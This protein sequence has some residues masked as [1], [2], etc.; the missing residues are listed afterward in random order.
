[1]PC[2]SDYMNPTEKESNSVEVLGFLKE[3]GEK[4][5]KYDSYYG[6]IETLD[7]DVAK[8]CSFCQKNDV[9]KYSLELQIWWRDHKKADKE[10]VKKEMHKIK[11]KEAKEKAL[12]K[13]T[14]YEKKLLGL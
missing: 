1:M 7:E 5:G 10:R 14:K 6:R 8:L 4:V 11:E 2:N 13:L 9:A 12:A 3:V